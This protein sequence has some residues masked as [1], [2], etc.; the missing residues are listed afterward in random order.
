MDV[1]LGHSLGALAAPKLCGRHGRLA[2][3]LVIEEPPAS[4]NYDFN[5][6]ARMVESD[7]ARAREAPEEAKREQ[8]EENPS[9]TEEDATNNVAI[10]R[11][12]IHCCNLPC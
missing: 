4:E 11:A 8:L 7:V 5:E 9:W 10:L 1:L 3:R 6:V 12:V 2:G